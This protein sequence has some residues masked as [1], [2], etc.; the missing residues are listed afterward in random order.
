MPIKIDLNS[1]K[2]LSLPS[3]VSL[4][5]DQLTD[6][7]LPPPSL[8]D[9][10]DLSLSANHFLTTGVIVVAMVWVPALAMVSPSAEA[11]LPLL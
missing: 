2:L 1:E 4:L 7:I 6:Q 5:K 8:N 9:V 3:P 11:L 10:M